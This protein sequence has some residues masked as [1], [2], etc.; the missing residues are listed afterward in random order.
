M[1]TYSGEFTT[2]G[3]S[4]QIRLEF[5]V[6]VISQ[7]IALNTSTLGWQLRMVEYVNGSPFR[8]YHDCVASASI[9]GSG[10]YYA[11]N[12][13]YN[14]DQTNE[15]IVIATGTRD[16][17]HAANGTKQI[18]VAASYDGKGVIGTASL[19]V[20]GISLP[21]IPRASTPTYSDSTPDAGDS[22]TITTNRA[23]GSFT[24]DLE[25]RWQGSGSAYTS[26]ATGVGAST[27]WTVPSSLINDIPN[28]TTRVLEIRTTTK[29]GATT[30]GTSLTT[31]TVGVPESVVPDFG[32]VTHAEAVSSPDIATLIGAY[33]QSMSK[34]TLAITSAVAGTGATVTKKEVQVR[35][36]GGTVLQTVD[37][38]AGSA[39][40]PN[41]LSA[42]GTLTLRGIVTDSRAR[43]YYEDVTV[44]VL[45][46][47]L[48]SVTSLGLQRALADGTPDEEGTYIRVDLNAAVQ[49]LLVSAVQKNA[50][51][52]RISTSPRDANTW[53]VKATTTPGGVT[54]NSHAEVGTYA[55]SDAWDVKVEVY[56]KLTSSAPLV[57]VGAIS[58]AGVF[59]H[60]GNAGEGIGLGEYWQ[61]GDPS[62]P[63]SLW[64]KNY[65]YQAGK[66]VLDTDDL[67]ALTAQLIQIAAMLGPRI[68]N[69]SFRTNQRVYTSGTAIPLGEYCFDRWRASG[70]TNQITNP[71][72]G[73]ATTN[74]NAS[75]NFGNLTGVSL[76]RVA[77]GGPTGAT[78]FARATVT[79]TGVTTLVVNFGNSGSTIVPIIPGRDYLYAVWVRASSAITVN[80]DAVTHNLAGSNV[81]DT[82]DTSVALAANTWT[83]IVHTFKSAAQAVRAS[84]R[85][86]ATGSIPNGMTLDVTGMTLVAASITTDPGYFDGDTSGCSWAGTAHA[87]ASY[88]KAAATSLTFTANPHFGQAVTLNSDGEL[89]TI[90]ER[91]RVPAGTYFL[92]HDGTAQMRIYNVG[93]TPPAYADGPLVV[94]LDGT[95]DVI[96]EFY[97]HGGAS[98]TIQNVRLELGESDPGFRLPSL[99][100]ELAE[101]WRYYW[102][103]TAAGAFVNLAPLGVQYTTT[104]G[105]TMLIPPVPMRPVVPG[106]LSGGNIGWSDLVSFNAS[107]TVYFDRADDDYRVI[108]VGTSFSAS[109][110]A[111]RP[112][113]IRSL[114]SAAWLALDS[115]V[116]A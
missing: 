80:V 103:A 114:G 73:S 74:W 59:M 113:T 116:Y 40:T 101:C 111:N 27:S 29:S 47:S 45:A 5:E 14:F 78:T 67:A 60:L 35:T 83:R 49:S 52:Y 38:T 70:L 46:Y 92:E 55:I 10:V 68:I 37:V 91:S 110:A 82:T 89:H 53:T 94:T 76:S 112:G 16:V 56:D 102:R 108:S 81:Q 90:L 13:D 97:A 61:E 54:F 69:G 12:L 50:L 87:S 26:I 57:I 93:T 48:P 88:N 77:T 66:L 41:T 2:P 62:K 17:A 23:D 8:N 98:K 86:Y 115:E 24:H 75:T 65:L 63:A 96:V 34:L 72:A 44:D 6:W 85:V 107:A 100:S 99:V 32:T 15:T 21:T 30:I 109:G 51:T 64:A 7:S 25:Y 19:S 105:G 84:M 22:I 28:A 4:A 3:T 71:R 33:V 58:T 39:A 43:T 1:A 95:A 106:V 31:V 36:A 42:S 20:G 11:A 104:T 79:S 9:D 18:S